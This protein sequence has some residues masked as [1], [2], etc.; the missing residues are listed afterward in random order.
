MDR[1]LIGVFEETDEVGLGRLLQHHDGGALGAQVGLEALRDLARGRGAGR[2]ARGS[3]APS[4]S[5]SGGSRAARPYP[6]GSGGA[7][8][9]RWWRAQICAPL[10]SP[11]AYGAPCRPCLLSATHSTVRYAPFPV[12]TLCRRSN[13]YVNMI[14]ISYDKSGRVAC[15][16]DR[17]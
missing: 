17:R 3:V 7:S 4:T 6:G 14:R 8:S 11:A 12:T 5:R 15:D 1:A 10:S 16:N 9:R 13:L 2:A